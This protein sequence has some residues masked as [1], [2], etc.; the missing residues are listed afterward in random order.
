MEPII[1]SIIEPVMK[2][3]AKP[4]ALLNNYSR[5]QLFLFLLFYSISSNL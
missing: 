5:I 3:T 2:L 4:A 1:K